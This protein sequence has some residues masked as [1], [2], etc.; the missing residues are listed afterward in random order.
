MVLPFIV[1]SALQGLLFWKM[2]FI[3]SKDLYEEYREDG[4]VDLKESVRR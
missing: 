2:A 4:G 3:F 1:L